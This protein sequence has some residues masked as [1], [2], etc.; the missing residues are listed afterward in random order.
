M[1]S[2]IKKIFE[3]QQIRFL[4]VGGLNTMVGYGT[5]AL[6]LWLGLNYF[7]SNSISYVIGIIHSYFWN[8]KFTFKSNDKSILEIVKFVSVYIVNYLVGIAFLSLFIKIFGINEYVAGVLNLVVTT[9]ISYFGHKYFSFS[10][11]NKGGNIE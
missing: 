3:Y 10:K 6:F 1:I 2:K 5:Y 7:Y 9:L 11:V 4:F 8:K